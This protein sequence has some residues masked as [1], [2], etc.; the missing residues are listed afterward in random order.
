[1]TANARPTS[2]SS[3]AAAAARLGSALVVV[4]VSLAV[5]TAPVSLARCDMCPA[6]LASTSA[7]ILA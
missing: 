7:V 3:A 2:A 6:I 5:F 4:A 1:M